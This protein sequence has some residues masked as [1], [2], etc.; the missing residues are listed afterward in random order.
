MAE[1]TSTAPNLV[2]VKYHLLWRDFSKV[3]KVTRKNSYRHLTQA[4]VLCQ[5][6]ELPTLCRKFIPIHLL[7]LLVWLNMKTTQQIL[8]GCNFYTNIV[9][10]IVGLLFFLWWILSLCCGSGTSPSTSC[11]KTNLTTYP[12]IRFQS[13]SRVSRSM[14][15]I[16]S[17]FTL[18]IAMSH[19]HAL[20]SQY[21]S[22]HSS[23]VSH[24]ACLPLTYAVADN[25]GTRRAPPMTQETFLSPDTARCR[26]SLSCHLQSDVRGCWYLTSVTPKIGQ[27][28]DGT[29][30]G[31]I[32]SEKWLDEW[33]A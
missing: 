12:E 8:V 29:L 2:L 22:Q 18:Q 13:F 5:Q 11:F 6:H 1:V 23:R 10:N 9:L 14:Q 17:D 21:T 24:G 3:W 20:D 15:L 33:L 27:K 4:F 16:N 19:T 25:Y 26:A 28:E 32:S 31:A 7:Y 30:S